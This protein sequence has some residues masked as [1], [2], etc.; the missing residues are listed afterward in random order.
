MN[1]RSF[2]KGLGSLLTLAYTAPTELISVSDD[3]LTVD[4]ELTSIPFSLGEFEKEIILPA[5]H[6]LADMIDRDLT[7]MIIKGK[8]NEIL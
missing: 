4:C 6:K 7:K 3:Y 8:I 2:L 5:V 1:R